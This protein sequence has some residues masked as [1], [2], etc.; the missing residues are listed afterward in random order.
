M[1]STQAPST[2][3]TQRGWELA[4][5]CGVFAAILMPASTVLHEAGHYLAGRV[6][7]YDMRMLHASTLG[8]PESSA[9]ASPPY[10]DIAAI[11]FA[12]PLVTLMIALAAAV[13]WRRVPTRDWAFALAFLAPIRMLTNVAYVAVYAFITILQMFQDLR[14]ES[15]PNFDEYVGAMALGITPQPFLVVQAV[16]LGAFWTWLVMTAP[17]GTRLPRLLGSAAG[18]GIGMFAWFNGLGAAL[19]G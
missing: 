17:P 9:I 18:A 5:R 4:L 14:W 11:A 19:M 3:A 10:W 12:G 1:T 2:L 15:N 6:F 13:A 16:A 8:A 7:G